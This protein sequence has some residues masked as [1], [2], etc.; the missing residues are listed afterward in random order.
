M[1]NIIYCHHCGGEI[2]SKYAKK[3]CNSSCAAKHNNKDRRRLHHHRPGR[4]HYGN[5]PTDCLHCGKKTS[6]YKRIYCS[7][8]CQQD[9]KYEHVTKISVLAGKAGV[10]PAKRYLTEQYG[11][12]CSE[13]GLSTWKDKEISLH[14]DHIDGNSDNNFPNNLRFLCPNCHSQTDTFG[15]TGQRKNTKRN[16]YL[17]VYKSNR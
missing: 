7:L 12:K 13:C 8:Q 11:Y 2:K 9:Y 3:F 17:R 14:M 4:R 6:G 16:K 10:A 15:W 1:S 5:P